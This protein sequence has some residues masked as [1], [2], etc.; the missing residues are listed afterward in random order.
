MT[1][2]MWDAIQKAAELVNLGTSIKRVDGDGWSVYA[3]GN[4]V[5]I[6]IKK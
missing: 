4:I 3:V 5:R 6:D 1:K 2:E